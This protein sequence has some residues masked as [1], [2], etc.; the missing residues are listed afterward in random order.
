VY[1]PGVL[2]DYFHY[3]LKC[4][5]VELLREIMI[6]KF[7]H[8]PPDVAEETRHCHDLVLLKDWVM[9]ANTA[10]SL[11][12]FRYYILHLAPVLID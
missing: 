10:E 7:G 8:V 3:R 4:A 12:E 6:G 9:A 1:D 11:D 5:G 2:D